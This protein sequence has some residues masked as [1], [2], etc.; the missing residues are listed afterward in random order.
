MTSSPQGGNGPFS[1]PEPGAPIRAS[2]AEREA[3]AAVLHDA[4]GR[5]LLTVEEANERV[6]AAYAARFV[7]ELPPLTA[8]LPPAPVPAP[9]APGWRA[10]AVLAWLQLRTALAGF[11]WRD[12]RSRPRLV[13]AV[14]GLL[15]VLMLGVATVG[16]FA[17]HGPEFR[18]VE[19]VG[20][21]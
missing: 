9:T 16:D 8:D 15:A 13:V 12:L 17:E 2:D 19:H 3:V 11:S 18:H 21:R 4:A 1:Q 5:G 20:P 6:S 10:L 14:V 7:H